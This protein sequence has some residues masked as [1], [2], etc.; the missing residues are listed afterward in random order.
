MRSRT[1]RSFSLRATYFG[2]RA[3]GRLLP[4]VE[5]TEASGLG[6]LRP[7]SLLTAVETN[8]PLAQQCCPSLAYAAKA[9]AIRTRRL[10]AA[11]RQLT[12]LELCFAIATVN[13][14]QDVLTTWS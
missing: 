13:P 2:W 8:Y 9:I 3:E 6:L 7:K 5:L 11:L 4:H 10:P 14:C 1:R 12:V